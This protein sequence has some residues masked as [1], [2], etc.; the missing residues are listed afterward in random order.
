MCGVIVLLAGAMWWG[1]VG[2]VWIAV[3]MPDMQPWLPMCGGMWAGLVA[4]LAIGAAAQEET[5]HGE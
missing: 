2:A 5:G 4:G 1:F 3:G